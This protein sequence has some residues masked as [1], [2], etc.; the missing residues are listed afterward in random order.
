MTRVT[1][2]SLAFG[3]PKPGHSLIARNWAQLQ[4]VA[5]FIVITDHIDEWRKTFNGAKHISLQAMSIEEFFSLA[6]GPLGMADKAAFLQK[7]GNRFYNTMNGWTACGLRP[8]LRKMIPLKD[9]PKYWGWID[10]DVL[11]DRAFLQEATSSSTTALY[12]PKEGIAWEQIKLFAYEFPL[13]DIFMEVAM[14]PAREMPVEAQ[15]VY[16]VAETSANIG[17]TKDDCPQNKIAA[18][19]A[20]TDKF[21]PL[22]NQFDVIV[23]DDASLFDSKGNPIAC[24]IADTQVKIFTPE[25]ISRIEND[26]TRT[27]QS[28]FDYHPAV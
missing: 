12:F 25:D 6:Y 9:R 1:F 3:L 20:F 23:H 10:W 19:W 8:L 14:A 28:Q 24:F 13:E 2:Y 22:E 16:T 4:D 5:D 21:R 7:Y 27:G 18:H 17:L 26:L 11:C 15:L